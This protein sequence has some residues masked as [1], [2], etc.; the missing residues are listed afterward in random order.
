MNYKVRY[1]Q[2]DEVGLKTNAKVG[3]FSQALPETIVEV[4]LTP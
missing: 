2:G 3:R 4:R 1:R